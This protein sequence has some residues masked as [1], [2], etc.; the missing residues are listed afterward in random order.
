MVIYI[1]LT[2]VYLTWNR[3]QTRDCIQEKMSEPEPS[4]NFLVP[5]PCFLH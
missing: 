4:S 1:N 3:S 2:K 5:Q